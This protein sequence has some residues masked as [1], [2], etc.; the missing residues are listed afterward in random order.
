M[1]IKMKGAANQNENKNEVLRFRF[2]ICAANSDS[3]SKKDLYILAATT[4][5]I[6]EV[7]RVFTGEPL[8]A[9]N[10]AL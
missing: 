1:K 3:S 9:L 4:F 8:S 10:A 2:S 6:P 5:R 7:S